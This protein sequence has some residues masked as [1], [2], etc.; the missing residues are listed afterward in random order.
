MNTLK[1][2]S[3]DDMEIGQTATYSKTLTEEDLVL[4]ARTSGDVNPVHLDEEFA[5]G[6]PFK[7]RI[8][9]GMWSAGLISCA[10]GTILP[11]PGT[12]YLGQNLSFRRP[13]LLGDTLTV[14]LTV[15]GKQDDKKWVTIDTDVVNQ[16]DKLVVKGDATVMAP[17]SSGE[18]EAPDLP[19]VT[20]G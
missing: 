2:T 12:V 9:H 1:S 8:A 13:V 3:Y 20:V 17:R 16:D 7:T 6:T 11:G 4:F 15:S 19:A 10:L 5:K 18:I 14:K